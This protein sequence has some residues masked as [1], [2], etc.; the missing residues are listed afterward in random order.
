MPTSERALLFVLLAAY[1]ALMVFLGWLGRRKTHGVEDYY[2]GGRSLGGTALGLSFF[3]TYAS[4]NSYLGFSGQ[5]YSYGI[6]WFLLVPA[7]AIFCWLSWRL[8]APRLRG[9][10]QALGS[11]TIPDY[12]GFRFGSKLARTAA[13]L[14]VLFASLLY[15]VAVF[16]GI[17]NLLETLLGISYPLAIS[18]VLVTVVIYTSVGGFHSVVRTDGVQAVLM[19]IAAVLLFTHITRATDGVGALARLADS[20]D[21]APLLGLES[22]LAFGTL[23]GV[24]IASTI[25][26][27]V[28][29]RQL[30]RFYALRSPEEAKRGI[31][32]ATAC[33][34]FVFSLLVPLGLYGRLLVGGLEDTD[35][36]VPQLIAN[37]EIFGGIA[38]SFLLLALVSA[39][40]SSLDSVLLVL[41]STCQRDL[42]EEAW[43][44]SG[45]ALPPE[46]TRLRSTRIQV[47]VLAVAT[48]LL[49]LNPPGGIVALTSFSGALYGACFLP[50]M[51]LGLYW[52]RG[53]GAAVLTSIGLGALVLAG[54]RFSEFAA[55]V[56]AVFP[57]IT[58]SLLGYVVVAATTK[59]AGQRAL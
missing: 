30:S 5:A 12:L 7:A 24:V 8:V 2:V 32:V 34:L 36:L 49:A 27:I 1:V 37:P 11:V 14:V 54:W 16:K 3:A 53:N 10:T 38:R 25:K 28:E 52:S 51:L 58:I 46:T 4:T 48:A 42:V 50:P 22:E 9:A 56:H 26:L 33:F 19:V 47:V 45:R 15:M 13:A 41:A 31:W 23:L 57:A 59:P 44:L 6:G 35:L 43:L 39:A 18:I 40:M 20:P 29:P 55:Y 21:T 17:G